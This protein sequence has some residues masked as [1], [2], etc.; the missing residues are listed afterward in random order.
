MPKLKGS[1]ES[2]RSSW[3]PQTDARLERFARQA[4]RRMNSEEQAGERDTNKSGSEE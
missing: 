1:R 4:R 3:G 2:D